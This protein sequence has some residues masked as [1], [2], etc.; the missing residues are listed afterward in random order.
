MPSIG[1]KKPLPLMLKYRTRRHMRQGNFALFREIVLD[2]W[3]AEAADATKAAALVESRVSEL[4]QRLQR[5]DERYLA[6]DIDRRSYRELRDRL[7]YDL[8][9]AEL[10]R[11]EARIEETDIEGFLAFAHHVIENATA[12]WTSASDH[13][14]RALQGAL[15][16]TGLNWEGAGFGTAVTCFAFRSLPVSKVGGN[17]MASPPGFEPG[18]QP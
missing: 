17:R 7:R 15:F 5:V 11:N 10:E 1:L 9:L 13:D 12:L 3:K 8:A 14:R 2:C 6:D 18:F 4:R 16:P